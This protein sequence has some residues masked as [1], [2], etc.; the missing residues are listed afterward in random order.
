MCSVRDDD[1]RLK[2]QPAHS[3]GMM[4]PLSGEPRRLACAGCGV[5]FECGLGGDCWCAAERYRLPMPAS[6][7]P[8]LAGDCLCP[9]CLRKAAAAT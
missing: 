1:L 9:A 2:S 6:Q 8:Q 3:P 7:I 5:R 4:H